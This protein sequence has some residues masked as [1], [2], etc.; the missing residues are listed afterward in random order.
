MTWKGYTAAM[1]LFQAR[2]S[3]RVFG[4]QE[5][6]HLLPLNPQRL[7]PVSP[8]SAV[9]HRRQLRHQHQLLGL[10]RGDDLGQAT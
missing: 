4:V 7:G 6:Q 5:L 8:D 9:Q 2:G 3:W 1:L 10:L